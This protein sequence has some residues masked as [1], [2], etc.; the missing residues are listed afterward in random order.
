MKKLF[1]RLAAVFLVILMLFTMVTGCAGTADGKS[2][3]KNQ[4]TVQTENTAAQ[5]TKS[6]AQTETN[7]KTQDKGS[8]EKDSDISEDEEYSSL[9]EVAEYL[10]LYGHL[11]DNYITKNEAKELGW[12]SREGNLWEVAPGKSIGG[13]YF[14]NREGHLPEK[15]GRKYYECDVDYYGGYRG[16]DR[17]IYSNDGLVYY[18]GDHYNTFELLYG[19]E[20]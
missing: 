3:N 18:T 5:D 16:D 19:S 4:T 13:D 10:Y 14:G 8:S 1:S 6:T 12:V 7:R 11:P 17:I 15:K 20:D 9:E 2:K